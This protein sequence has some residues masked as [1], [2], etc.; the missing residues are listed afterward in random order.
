MKEYYKNPEAT[1]EAFKGGWFHSGDLVRQ[2]DEG[3]IYVVD[4]K[5]DM[6]IS[7]GHNIY[8]AELEEVLYTHPKILE[9][10]VIGVPDPEWGESVKAIVVP[11][12]GETLT[13]AEVIEYCKQNLASYKKPKSVELVGELPRNVTGK[14]L[15]R[16]LREKYGKTG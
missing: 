13:E 5:K 3:Y 1:A 2:D 4:R 9:A 16:E 7:G 11:K 10:A 8:P 6:I 14:V 15:K 12:A